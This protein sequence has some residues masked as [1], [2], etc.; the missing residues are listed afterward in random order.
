MR[1]PTVKPTTTSLVSAVLAAAGLDPTFV[2]G[3]VVNSART[4]ARLGRGEYLVAEA[5]ESDASFLHLQPQ[6]AVITNI[7]DDHM[8]AYG[9]DAERLRRTYL[10]FLHN[11]PFYGLAVLCFDDVEV[12]KLPNELTRRH[13]SYGL[14][15]GADYRA[16][17]L[18][19]HG[20]NSRFAVESPQGSLGEFCLSMPGEHNVQNALAAITLASS[21]Q[22]G[23]E[24]VRRALAEFEGIDRRFQVM[25]P[26]K[27][28]GGEVE[29]V[30]DYAHHPKEIRATLKATRC[31]WPERRIV[32]VFQPHRYSRT[33]DLFDQFVQLLSELDPLFVMDVY[34][35]GETPIREA[36]GWSL[37]QAIRQR[38]SE[39]VFVP[40]FMELKGPAGPGSMPG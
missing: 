1:A 21:L 29:M 10:A 7:D 32:T 22:I 37:C 9:G 20:H 38:G 24:P 8:E 16:T 14:G 23:M 35:A 3:G 2:I 27:W 5:D 28:P 19:F 13:L 33:R 11:L 15:A 6:M 26:L 25:G 34:P 17:D 4:S 36:D 18:Q 30:D 31:C 39:V 40:D 12:R